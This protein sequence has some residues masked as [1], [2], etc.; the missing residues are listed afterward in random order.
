M[1][2][3]ATHPAVPATAPAAPL[4]VQDLGV[5]YRRRRGT[6]PA[7]VVH[8]VSFTVEAGQT[9]ALVGQSGSGKSTVARAVAGLLPG[10][11]AVTAGSVHVA[12]HPVSSFTRRQWRPL[13][14]SAL[15][16][17]PQ[18]PLSSLDPLQRVGTQLAA[19]LA[20]TGFPRDRVA[21]RVVELLDH[22]G[23]PDAAHK[24]RAYPHELSGGQLQRVLIA[25]AI[26]AGP[27][28]LVAD[29]PTSALDVTVQKRILDLVDGLRA[30]LGLGVLFITHDLALAQERSDEVVVLRDGVVREH[31]PVRQVLVAPRDPYTVTLLGDA[32]SSAPDRY[33]DRV[34]VRAAAVGEPV[35]EVAG[36]SKVFAARGRGGAAVQAL[37]DVSLRLSRGSV[38]AL[39]GESGSGKTTLG[40]VVAGLTAF[41]AG[42]VAVA[43]RRLPAEPPYANPFARRLQMVYQNPLSALDPRYSVRRVLEEPL[44]VHRIGEPA[45]R[46]ERVAR[47]LDQV[48]LPSDV[49][50]RGVRE[51][52]GGQRQRVALARTLLL[53][54]QVLVLDEPTSALDVTV[55]AQIVD[56]LLSLQEEQGL[57]YLFV[58]HDLGLVRQ[59]ADTVTVLQRGRVVEQGPVDDVFADP[60]EAYMREL[61]DAV[62]RLVERAAP[63]G[64]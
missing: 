1:T 27:A 34:T 46:R 29:E 37:D 59:V 47:I 44:R 43:G 52:S 5:G 35:V 62:P 3:T 50:V 16:F 41:D 21:E 42:E 9:V 48:A 45:Q 13:R 28:L 10:N 23:I 7:D 49:L 24:A 12:G 30:E 53:E 26:A 64:V 19:A 38:H 11:G 18:D 56:L 36:V 14:G 20:P 39:V 58:T 32:P 51:L 17:V 4:V 8:G 22:V 33:R 31:G 54:P 40:R 25:I 57:S 61:L 15:G 63:V 60:R 55:Q 6:R 2:A